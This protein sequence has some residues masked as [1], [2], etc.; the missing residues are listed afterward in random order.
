MDNPFDE[1]MGHR[2]EMGEEY[3][4]QERNKGSEE[5]TRPLLDNDP[6]LNQVGHDNQGF[7]GV[8]TETSFTSDGA[9]TSQPV[10]TAQGDLNFTN[11]Y[12]HHTD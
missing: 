1:N 2:E 6:L 3:E 10:G 11:K 5:D 12:I 4:M 7:Q 8:E 9:S